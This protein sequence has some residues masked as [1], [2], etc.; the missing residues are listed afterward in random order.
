MALCA[1]RVKVGGGGIL[2][3]VVQ[4]EGHVLRRYLQGCSSLAC[5][6]VKAGARWW[7]EETSTELST[8]DPLVVVCVLL[9]RSLGCVSWCDARTAAPDAWDLFACW[10]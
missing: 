5:M 3:M 8:P 10:M 6:S 7:H 1:V 2:P 9:C 4:A